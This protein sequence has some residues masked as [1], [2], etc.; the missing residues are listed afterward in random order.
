MSTYFVVKARINL[1][2]EGSTHT[3][4]GPDYELGTVG[5]MLMA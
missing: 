3:K 2:D 5:T 4:T 1:P